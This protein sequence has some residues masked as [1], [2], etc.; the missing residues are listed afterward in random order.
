M[1][2]FYAGSLETHQAM[3]HI[4]HILY[5]SPQKEKKNYIPKIGRFDRVA[6]LGLVGRNKFQFMKNFTFYAM[7]SLTRNK[8]VEYFRSGG[9][10]TSL[11]YNA[12]GE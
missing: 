8:T 9:H 4:I 11:G 3:A 6:T 5:L 12:R 2:C 10:V 7:R 1:Y